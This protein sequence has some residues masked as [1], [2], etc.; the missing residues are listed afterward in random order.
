MIVE[1]RYWMTQA[2]PGPASAW[3]LAVR[4]SDRRSGP[5]RARLTPLAFFFLEHITSLKLTPRTAH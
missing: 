4:R 2:G 1:A 5:R 3:D